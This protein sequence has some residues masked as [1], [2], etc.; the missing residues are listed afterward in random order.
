MGC[1]KQTKRTISVKCNTQMIF[2]SFI[3]K[4]VQ[5][6][7]SR[8]FS[9][10]SVRRALGGAK[11]RQEG[12]RSACHRHHP[13]PPGLF[14]LKTPRSASFQVTPERDLCCPPL[15]TMPCR[16]TVGFWSRKLHPGRGRVLGE[17][18]VQKGRG[19]TDEAKLI[20][21]TIKSLKREHVF[22]R[23]SESL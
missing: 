9:S 4:A 3:S 20:L 23:D 7:I 5:M 18:I 17:G 10:R 15:S 22:S 12:G 6:R 13:F 8:R 21:E 11:S 19:I 2:G 14:Y 1:R 16:G